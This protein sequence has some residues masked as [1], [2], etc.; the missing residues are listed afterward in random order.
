MVTQSWIGRTDARP[1]EGK[2]EAA[3]DEFGTNRNTKDDRIDKENRWR[4]KKREEGGRD[5]QT[6]TQTDAQRQMVKTRESQRV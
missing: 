2:R 4:R 5:R 3:I 1:T 6:E